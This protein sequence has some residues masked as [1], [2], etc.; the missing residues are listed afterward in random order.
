VKEEEEDPRDAK[1]RRKAEK[2]L[3]KKIKK[4]KRRAEK[5]KRREHRKRSESRERSRRRA[6]SR[7]RSPQ[8]RSQHEE[9]RRGKIGFIIGQFIWVVT[10]SCTMSERIRSRDPLRSPTPSSYSPLPKQPREAS[11]TVNREEENSLIW[12]NCSTAS[13]VDPKVVA[14]AGAGGESLS[15]D[16]LQ[17]YIPSPITEASV[18]G[19]EC[20][21]KA[22]EGVEVSRGSLD[23][24]E[25]AEMVD[26]ADESSVR[27]EG[28]EES[29]MDSDED[30]QQDDREDKD[31]SDVQDEEEYDDGD[32]EE[33]EE[34]GDSQAGEHQVEGE[35][36]NTLEGLESWA[37]DEE[38]NEN[39]S[40]GA[41]EDDDGERVEEDVVGR[42]EGDEEEAEDG[43]EE[44]RAEGEGGVVLGGEHD[45]EGEDLDTVVLPEGHQAGGRQDTE[46]LR[47]TDVDDMTPEDS[48]QETVKMA[49]PERPEA[50]FPR[51]AAEARLLLE[52]LT[53]EGS[54]LSVSAPFL[55]SFIDHFITA[56]PED[57]C[58]SITEVKTYSNL[59]EM[60]VVIRH[61]LRQLQRRREAIPA[62]FDILKAEVELSDELRRMCT[63][64]QTDDG[65]EEQ[66]L[67]LE[68]WGKFRRLST[69]SVCRNLAKSGRLRKLVQ[70]TCRHARE[71]SRDQW[72]E[73]CLLLEINEGNL[74]KVGEVL[75][76]WVK[77][78]VVPYVGNLSGGLGTVAAVADHL[79][80][81][82]EWATTAALDNAVDSTAGYAFAVD[83]LGG[84][85][86][87]VQKAVAL[88]D[89]EVPL[90]RTPL[91]W[92]ALGHLRG[93]MDKTTFLCDA[94]KLLKRL[95][96]CLE[97]RQSFGIPVN[98]S[99]IPEDAKSRREWFGRAGLELLKRIPTEQIR[100]IVEDSLYP[101]GQRM[102]LD[103]PI[104]EAVTNILA[105][106]AARDLA[107]DSVNQTTPADFARV[108]AVFVCMRTDSSRAR[109]LPHLVWIAVRCAASD[110]VDDGV[111]AASA[112]LG[113]AERI[114]EEAEE[115]DLEAE[116][117]AGVAANKMRI[118]LHKEARPHLPYDSV[119][120][121]PDALDAMLPTP[122]VVFLTVTHLATREDDG[123]FRA[124]L[125]IAD[126][127]RKAREE[128]DGHPRDKLLARFGKCIC[129]SDVFSTRLMSIVE[130]SLAGDATTE[131]HM[132][133]GIAKASAVFLDTL[134]FESQLWGLRSCIAL[135]WARCG[136]PS[137]GLP[138]YCKAGIMLAKIALTEGTDTVIQERGRCFR[139]S[140]SLAEEFGLEALPK[141]L[142]YSSRTEEADE[143]EGDDEEGIMSGG[144]LAP[145]GQHARM[146]LKQLFRNAASPEA[147]AT[148]GCRYSR[149]S[150]LLGIPR[151]TASYI[152]ASNRA[153]EPA[154]DSGAAHD[155]S[156]GR[157]LTDGSTRSCQRA[158]EYIHHQLEE[159]LLP[160][161]EHENFSHVE[162]PLVDELSALANLMARLASLCDTSMLVDEELLET[163]RRLQL[164]T[165]LVAA[166]DA[167]NEENHL[168]GYK[169]LL[170]SVM[171]WCS[172]PFSLIPAVEAFRTAVEVACGADLDNSAVEGEEVEDDFF[173]DIL[174][175]QNWAIAA[176]VAGSRR[177]DVLVEWLRRITS[178][179]GEQDALLMLI[180]GLSLPET[181][182]EE[183]FDKAIAERR[184]SGQASVASFLA[185]TASWLP[186]LREF[187][188]D[189]ALEQ[190]V[191]RLQLADT[192]TELTVVDAT[193]AEQQP[194]AIVK[195]F[196]ND[197][198]TLFARK[199]LQDR[200]AIYCSELSVEVD[201]VRLGEGKPEY[202]WPLMSRL[203]AAGAELESVQVLATDFQLPQWETSLLWCSTVIQR[204]SVAKLD[205]AW[206]ELDQL[207]T[208]YRTE[209]LRVIECEILGV[210][211]DLTLIEMALDRLPEG[212]FTAH[213]FAAKAIR[214]YETQ[215]GTVGNLTLRKMVEDPQCA[216]M[217]ELM[218]RNF[219]TVEAI[220][221]VIGPESAAGFVS[222]ASEYILHHSER[223]SNGV[224][225]VVYGVG[226]SETDG[227]LR[228]ENR[229]S[230][231]PDHWT[232]A[233]NEQL[234][235][236]VDKL[237]EM[238]ARAAEIL[239]T[240]SGMLPVC[241]DKLRVWQRMKALEKEGAPRHIS[242]AEINALETRI[243]L[244]GYPKFASFE[245]VLVELGPWACAEAIGYTGLVEDETAD[246]AYELLTEVLALNRVKLG[247]TMREL[248]DKWVKTP[249]KQEPWM[250]LVKFRRE[251]APKCGVDI[252]DRGQI[253]RDDIQRVVNLL[254]RYKQATDLA[255]VMVMLT[256]FFECGPTSTP[257]SRSRAGEIVLLISDISDIESGYNHEVDF[258]APIRAFYAYVDAAGR[259][260]GDSFVRALPTSDATFAESNKKQI[261]K[262]VLTAG[263]VHAAEFAAALLLDYP[264]DLGCDSE[265]CALLCE[266][267]RLLPKGTAVGVVRKLI[268]SGQLTALPYHRD[269]N[270]L[271]AKLGFEYSKSSLGPLLRASVPWV[272]EEEDTLRD[273]VV[274]LRGVFTRQLP[275]FMDLSEEVAKALA[276]NGPVVALESTIITHGMPYPQNLQSALEVERVVREA[277]SVP[278]TIA[279]MKGR[280]KVGLTEAEIKEIAEMGPSKC[281]KVSIRDVGLV[282]ANEG[283]G[284]TT[285]A[286]TMRIAAMA[287]IRIFATGGIGGVH[288]GVESTWDVSA[289][290]TELGST[291]VAV[292]C[293]GA[294]SVLDLPKT[295]EVVEE[296]LWPCW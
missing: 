43:V 253:D 211:Q 151:R 53:E 101:L 247:V 139:R 205:Q 243:L 72:V 176:E 288:R 239:K 286:A 257:A 84:V 244:R 165:R 66:Q 177:V 178:N 105:R 235:Q 281:S 40:E 241:V 78:F 186:L 58:S 118:V 80:A 230:T 234:L 218:D 19:E 290:L 295:L 273:A 183:T 274:F 251:E 231:E 56:L 214:N 161:V 111:A 203:S 67:T 138:I 279:I 245:P 262:T 4:D 76:P 263:S 47:V 254:S 193:V 12:A 59:Q 204:H 276:S 293:A 226:V 46:P 195:A 147:E 164:A 255:K 23:S 258:L 261:A 69:P 280:V 144:A 213:R 90:S 33:E 70:V 181:V 91:H 196:E 38:E 98:L 163:G 77:H 21:A 44:G 75:V 103:C 119:S 289:D 133:E 9:R 35:D 232:I 216:L 265:T 41:E 57:I 74:E 10:V 227:C 114:C 7:S 266:V 275:D 68:H 146:K 269:L 93:L 13:A 50:P 87:S 272:E 95:N 61:T 296:G 221:A 228:V 268:A 64:I 110:A 171:R 128:E 26:A 126:E 260:L 120:A 250:G 54:G 85:I 252:F 157:L 28:D 18:I 175:S 229:L 156:M 150:E 197:A 96:L 173:S 284:S 121:A 277:G 222:D 34:K 159:R 112:E 206:T 100:S 233:I 113:E 36:A 200:W 278:A 27:E 127:C 170:H 167:V 142:W 15:F 60:A 287:G 246:E 51:N 102:D 115:W 8:S 224:L 155:G 24:G 202:M 267:L 32:E 125:R 166:S 237:K 79:K 208:A 160:M 174:A 2:K 45:E 240:L 223:Q 169:S 122:Q 242:S 199:C 81:L 140:L 52:K 172:S 62:T 83:L 162:R 137:A 180:L 217:A 158:L 148:G 5:E 153:N 89:V 141:D 212:P 132:L 134:P 29:E 209:T 22:V 192:C 191:S 49:E 37:E 168:A 6:S 249:A 14:E 264:E 124:A 48:T 136:E 225:A 179:V 16:C 291:P 215:A 82:V 86:S 30:S 117:R 194:G 220:L 88:P 20:V 108:M 207:L 116:D 42:A 236:L 282:M 106:Y 104:E 55:H 107:E 189:D 11:P 238:P 94:E 185:G 188:V 109:I 71:L 152:L 143:G 3:A 190:E 271:L 259:V 39:D 182:S 219:S 270:L 154:P 123:A 65:S 73:L 198:Y 145:A 31:Q 184:A 294:K 92:A 17:G 99:D 97:V 130:G 248:A 210:V 283:Y 1:A 149:L 292:V 256:I 129:P 131:A 187:V 25:E 201:P 285:V 135:L 63:F